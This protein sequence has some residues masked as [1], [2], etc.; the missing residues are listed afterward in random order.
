MNN[1]VSKEKVSCAFIKNYKPRMFKVNKSLKWVLDIFFYLHFFTYKKNIFLINDF[2]Y[3]QNVIL[4]PS[5]LD[6]FIQ[7]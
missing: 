2:T 1:C 5:V 3:I 7:R 6:Y 4:Y